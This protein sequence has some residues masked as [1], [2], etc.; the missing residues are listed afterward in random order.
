LEAPPV[1]A[2]FLAAVC[3]GVKT[4]PPLQAIE[5]LT[6]EAEF[7]DLATGQFLLP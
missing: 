6:L 2:V 7:V 1:A 4:N 5:P 3:A